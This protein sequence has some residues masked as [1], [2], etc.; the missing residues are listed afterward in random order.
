MWPSPPLYT[1]S[2]I[3]ATSAHKSGSFDGGPVLQSFTMQKLCG[4][5]GACNNS[6]GNRVHL[7]QVCQV[8]AMK[9]GARTSWLVER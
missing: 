8:D 2:M 7:M 9:I 5:L 1:V 3:A 4:H 6:D